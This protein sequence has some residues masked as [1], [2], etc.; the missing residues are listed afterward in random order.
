MK[1]EDGGRSGNAEEGALP[2]LQALTEVTQFYTM[3][4]L[5]FLIKGSRATLGSNKVALDEEAETKQD[6]KVGS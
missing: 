3:T 6:L 2:T 1:E 5:G 4:M